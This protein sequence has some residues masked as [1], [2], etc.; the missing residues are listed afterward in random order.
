MRLPKSDEFKNKR[1][2]R[3]FA[4]PHIVQMLLQV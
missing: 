1:G 4:P 2:G 3:Y